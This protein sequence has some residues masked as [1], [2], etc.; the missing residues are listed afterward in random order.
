MKAY[1]YVRVS[2]KGQVEGDGF[3]RQEE[4]LRGYAEKHNVT[5]EKV[6]REEGFS[7]TKGEEERPAFKEMLAAILKDGVRT[8]I[9]ERL[10]R[11]ARELRIQEQLLIYLA[12]HGIELISADTEENVTEA[13]RSDPM[14]KAMVQV[15]GVFAELDKSLLVKKLRLARER[16]REAHGKCEG[17]KTYQEAAPEVIREIKRLRRKPRGE[18]AKR[19]TYRQIADELNQKGYKTRLGKEFTGQ[20]VQNIMR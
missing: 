2:G 9:V 6:Y 17:R 12:S 1:G 13:V 5:I 8:I 14:R 15:Q 20:V 19:M 3:T 16:V 18:G 11:L 10:D 4:A 7:G